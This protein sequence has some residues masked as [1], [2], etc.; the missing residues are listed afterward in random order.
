[1]S[2]PSAT[3][4]VVPLLACLSAFHPACSKMEDYETPKKN[5]DRQFVIDAA[6]ANWNEIEADALAATN[7]NDG[8]TRDFAQNMVDEHRAAN[9]LLLRISDTIN[10]SAPQQPDSVHREIRTILSH[11][12]GI[13]FDTTYLRAQVTD[14]RQ[15]IA[16]FQAELANGTNA[17]VL[18]YAATYLPVIH[19][20]LKKAD[21]LLAALSQ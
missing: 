12:G 6:Y 13:S 11:L 18:R 15:T 9:D 19:I 21:S 14:H 4:I 8:R 10:L 3:L 5:P 17:S 2:Q 20:H 1:M 16:L 7:G